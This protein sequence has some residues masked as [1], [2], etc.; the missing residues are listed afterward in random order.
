MLGHGRGGERLISLICSL[1]ADASVL[2][3]WYNWCQLRLSDVPC[4]YCG[5]LWAADAL[6]LN[7]M[8][9]CVS[10]DVHFHWNPSSPLVCF[11]PHWLDPPSLPHCRRPLWMTPKQTVMWLAQPITMLQSRRGYNQIWRDP[12]QI[13]VCY[14]FSHLNSNCKKCLKIV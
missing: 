10:A 13:L 1:S 2:G 12:C 4:C 6:S 11:C 8:P 9:I 3:P 5:L 7:Q 14:W